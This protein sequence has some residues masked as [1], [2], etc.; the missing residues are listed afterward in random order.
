MGGAGVPKGEEYVANCL[1][2]NDVVLVAHGF[3]ETAAL[4]RGLGHDV[5]ELGMSDYR[6][7]DGGLSCLS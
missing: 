2:V 5:V 1:R 4:L 7:T 6:K 3:P